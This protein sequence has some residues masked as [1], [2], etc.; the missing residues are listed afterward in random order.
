M[1][2]VRLIRMWRTIYGSI[3]KQQHLHL[4]RCHYNKTKSGSSTGLAAPPDYPAQQF[5]T[6]MD[7]NL[8]LAV[9]SIPVVKN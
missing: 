9:A 5:D 3:D 4:L 1:V 8:R 6:P 7:L 2:Q